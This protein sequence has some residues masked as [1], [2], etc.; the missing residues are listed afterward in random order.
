MSTEQNKEIVR[1]YLLDVWGKYDFEAE[2]ELVAEDLIDHNAVPHLPP[3]LEGHHQFLVMAQKAIPELDV[4]IDALFVEG[5]K[6]AYHWTAQGTHQG[7][8]LGIP[9][10][11]KTLTL[12]GSDIVR[13]ENGKIVE[14]WHF[15]DNLGLMQQ[16]GVVPP[17]GQNET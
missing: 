17:P 8:Y 11:G 16:L 6:V 14:S 15:E 10:T 3:G 1:R 12:T 13:I 5:N 9:P 4:T 7:E 2:Q